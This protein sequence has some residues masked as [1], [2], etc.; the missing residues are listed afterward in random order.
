[1]KVLGIDASTMTGLS[2]STQPIL[3]GILD[4][5]KTNTSLRRYPRRLAVIL[6]A[7]KNL[8]TM[9]HQTLRLRLRVTCQIFIPLYEPAAHERFICYILFCGASS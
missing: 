5:A 9:A 4:A 7:A 2:P 3:A 6:S 8:I 1:M